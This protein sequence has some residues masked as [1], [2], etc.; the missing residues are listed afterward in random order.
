MPRIV[1]I[2]GQRFGKLIVLE[3]T[4]KPENVTNRCAY[5]LCKCDCGEITVKSGSD[6]RRGNTTSCGCNIY[7]SKNY[8]NLTGQKFGLLT[9]IDLNN[10]YG[11][12]VS[13]SHHCYW[14]CKCE[15]GNICICSSS[16]LLTGKQSC[17]CIK[18]H[19]EAKIKHI[20]DENNIKYIHDKPYF[21][22]LITK[23]GGVARYDFILLDENNVPFRLI[24]FDGEQ[25]KYNIFQWGGEEG[26]QVRKENDLLKN[27]YALSHNLPLIRI[28]YSQ[29]D[30]I[31]LD[32]I[33]GNN[34]LVKGEK[35]ND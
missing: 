29:R 30:K 8:K 33:L 24:E 21:K 7:N 5:W 34:F 3:K 35:E 16:S 10:D 18:S 12:Q 2:T 28:P 17:G 9:V 23:N 32:L 15:C 1:D 6:L 4:K 11:L 14:N 13:H 31:S 27:Q 26:L 25:H 22:D 19:A 20:L